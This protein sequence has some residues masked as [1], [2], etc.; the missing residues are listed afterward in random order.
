MMEAEYSNTH[1]DVAEREVISA[2]LYSPFIFIEVKDSLRAELFSTYNSSKAYAAILKLDRQGK[3]PDIA[4]VGKML[5]ADKVDVGYFFSEQKPDLTLTKQRIAYLEDLM[6]RRM[7]Y[8][9]CHH[10]E[11]TASD[12]FS[13]RDDFRAVYDMLGRIFESGK[14]ET[15]VPFGEVVT[16]LMNSIADRMNGK[17]ELGIMTGLH[18]FDSRFGL[19]D[20]DFVVIAG[21]TSQGKST[22]AT[23]LAY[24]LAIVGVPSVFYSMEMSA[25]QLAARIIARRVKIG[26]AR[27]LRDKL[28][29]AEF[30][31]LY[32][33]ASVLKSLPIYFDERSKTTFRGICDSIRRMVKVYNVRVAFIDYL[34][35][36]ANGKA[37]NR[38]Q[39][40]GDMARDLK[41]LAVETGICIVALSQM[42]RSSGGKSEPSLSRMRGSGQIEEACDMAVIIHRKDKQSEQATLSLEKSRNGSIGKEKVRFDLNYSYISDYEQGDPN[43]PYQEQK[44]PLPF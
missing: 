22:L 15:S 26:S 4:E 40:L 6:I 44:A 27:T 33:N 31:Q 21:E 42:S 16:G 13:T 24:N 41:R 3:V 25:R 20:G 11:V 5:E 39:I 14:S 38:E 17:E 29:D 36:L 19:H 10:G 9:V 30:S 35:I 2:L 32:D 18:L 8:N 7:L 23:T 43:A 28:S 1:N 12:P 37:E 34:Q